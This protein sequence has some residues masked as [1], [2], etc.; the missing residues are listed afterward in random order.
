MAAPDLILA[1]DGGASSTRCAIATARGEILGMGRAGPID[2]VYVREGRARFRAAI[3]EAVARATAAAGTP[4]PFRYAVMGLTGMAGATREAAYAARVLRSCARVRRVRVE[5]DVVTAFAGA[6]AGGPGIMV[7]AGTGAI[8]YGRNA[9]GEET[10]A[11]GYGWLVDDAGG[12]FSIGQAALRAAMRAVDGRGPATVLTRD[13]AGAM[14][15]PMEPAAPEDSIFRDGA[16]EEIT[17]L[18]TAVRARVYGP[19]GGRAFVASLVPLVTRGAAAGD[20]VARGIL[21]EAGRE[22]G[23]LAVA[24]ARSLG[25]L[26]GRVAVATSGGVFRAGE[27][28]AGPM[29]EALAQ[30]LPGGFLTAPRFPP[31]V[32]AVLLACR[33]LGVTPDA[34]ALDR[35]AAAA[36]QI[37]E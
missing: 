12:G 30:G 11:G 10:R 20:A 4:G 8:A 36:A 31:I 7:Y 6:T 3:Q 17:G 29:R 28:V 34:A 33:D 32:G 18:W 15:V 27:W 16:V 13:L 9:R 35:L 14:G 23:T 26:E 1:V 22:L 2:F 25:M 37:G 19:E 5:G 24:A 21:A